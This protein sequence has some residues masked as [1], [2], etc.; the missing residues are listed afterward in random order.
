M[1]N[2]L[3]FL[4]VTILVIL[5]GCSN[6]S[7]NIKAVSEPE[8]VVEKYFLA[9]GTEDYATMYGFISDGFKAIEP[10]AASLEDFQ[11]YA[12]SQGITKLSIPNV[13]EKSNNGKEAVVEYAVEFYTATNKIPFAGSFTLKYR[14]NDKVPGWKMIH[15]YGENIDTT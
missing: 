12:S 7:D 2:S 5:T 9:W 8:K 10:T 11:K 1:K 3:F 14:E 15:P 4:F 6:T 13:E